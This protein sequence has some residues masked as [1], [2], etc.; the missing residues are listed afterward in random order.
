VLETVLD[1]GGITWIDAIAPTEDEL[2]TLAERFRLHRTAIADC[3][4]P[5]HL[6]KFQ[7][8]DGGIVFLIARAFDESRERGESVQELTRKLALFAGPNVLITVH[9]VDQPYLAE[10]KREWRARAAG[11]TSTPALHVVNDLLHGVFATFEASLHECEQR[12]DAIEKHA[13]T[14]AGGFPYRDGFHLQ[15]ELSLVKRVL[16]MNLEAIRKLTACPTVE[17]AS[18]PFFQDLREEGERLHVAADDTSETL[19]DI[20]NL[21][22]ALAGQRTNEASHR[23]NEVMRLLTL[24]SALFLPL[25]FLA[26]VYGMNFDALPG[27]KSPDGPW[28]MGGV[29]AAVAAGSIGWFLRRGWLERRDLRSHYVARK[30]APSGVR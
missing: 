27:I 25:N 20:L 1:G 13:F 9:R 10:R 24:F 15:R 7:E 4:Q 14:T 16:W 18:K 19:R 30:R 5:Q 3:M 23:I 6:P 11:G 21:T 12:L 17:A 22:V 2:A 28:V 8:F 26:G 29:M